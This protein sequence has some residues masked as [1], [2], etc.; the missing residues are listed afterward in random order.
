MLP[1]VQ[2]HPDLSRGRTCENACKHGAAPHA[3]VMLFCTR[4][5]HYADTV[6]CQVVMRSRGSRLPVQISAPCAW[7]NP[8]FHFEQLAQ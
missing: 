6:G 8:E 7:L 4:I 2:E 1:R 5:L 3:G